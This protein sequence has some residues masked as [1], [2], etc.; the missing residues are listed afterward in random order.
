M[1]NKVMT[2]AA[3]LVSF[4]GASPIA[5]RDAGNDLYWPVTEFQ[6]SKPHLSAYVK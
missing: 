6:A 4:A 3:G 5:A 1:V 2:L